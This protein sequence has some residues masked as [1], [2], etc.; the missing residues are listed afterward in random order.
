M[1]PETMDLARRALS[2]LSDGKFEELIAMTDPEVKWHSFFAELGQGGVYSGHEGMREYARDL[3][4]AWDVVRVEV[5]HALPAGETALLVGRI[6]YRGKTS[7]VETKDPAGW[8]LRFRNGKVIQ[9]RAFRDPERALGD[10]GR[11]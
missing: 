8:S 3:Q 1:A 6:H 7:G 5:D 11:Q 2:L 10:V 4:D 9:F